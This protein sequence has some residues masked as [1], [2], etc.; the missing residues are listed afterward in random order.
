VRQTA[1]SQHPYDGERRRNLR[2]KPSS[3]IYVEIDSDSGGILLNLGVGGLAFQ[4][5]SKVSRKEDL[6]LKFRLS[7]TAQPI[8]LAGGI[9][10]QSL[11]QTEGGVYFENLST[12]AKQQIAEWIARQENSYQPAIPSPFEVPR[13]ILAAEVAKAT[14]ASEEPFRHTQTDKVEKI[15]SV[16]HVPKRQWVLPESLLPSRSVAIAPE[17]SSPMP[18]KLQTLRR[19]HLPLIMAGSAACLLILV[20]ILTIAHFAGQPGPGSLQTAPAVS[21]S[22]G[23]VSQTPIPAGRPA[24]QESPGWPWPAF[25]KEIFPGLGASTKTDINANQAGVQVWISKQS[26]YYYCSGSADFR[27]SQPGSLMTQ[28][29]ALQSGYQ[30]RLG[31]LCN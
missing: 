4:A 20:L 13:P 1:S 11:T 2:Q 10:W 23:S 26:G 27:T 31:E 21:P 28:S 16:E 8:E 3:L 15:E 7:E 25:L 12:G 18:A 22:G 6:T 30:P 14:P 5:V 19:R 29:E 9:A 17:P 24:V